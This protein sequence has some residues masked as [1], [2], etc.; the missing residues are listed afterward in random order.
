MKEVIQL[1]AVSFALRPPPH[2]SS[3]IH[4]QPRGSLGEIKKRWEKEYK[5][6]KPSPAQW[7]TESEGGGGWWVRSCEI[8]RGINFTPDPLFPL[9]TPPLC[10]ISLVQSTTTVWRPFPRRGCLHRYFHLVGLWHCDDKAASKKKKETLELEKER[11]AR[12]LLLLGESVQ[13]LLSLW[14]SFAHHILQAVVRDSS[15]SN[16]E[17]KIGN[18]MV[19]FRLWKNR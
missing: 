19:V 16:I 6:K 13:I 1:S 9:F 12:Q 2:P 11:S 4:L 10:R 3:L 15:E 17:E 8:G 5:K 14:D 7:L 18:I